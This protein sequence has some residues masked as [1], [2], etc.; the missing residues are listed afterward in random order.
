MKLI[1]TTPHHSISYFY[2]SPQLLLHKL[3]TE[4][5]SILAKACGESINTNMYKYTY[6]IR[7][8][9]GTI[10]DERPRADQSWPDICFPNPVLSVE[11]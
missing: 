5:P 4:T 3:L 2:F 1:I 7:L 11:A 10:A 8:R 9:A 6:I